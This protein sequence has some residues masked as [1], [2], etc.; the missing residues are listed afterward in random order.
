MV[1]VLRGEQQGLP[2]PLAGT[3]QCE[4]RSAHGAGQLRQSPIGF[5]RSVLAFFPS[6]FT[7]LK[8]APYHIIVRPTAMNHRVVA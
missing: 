6:Y 2:L 7:L 5:S 1:S 8:T 4:G 3:S